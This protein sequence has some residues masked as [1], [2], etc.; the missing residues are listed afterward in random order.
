M[1]RPVKNLTVSILKTP[2]KKVSGAGL[3]QFLELLARQSSGSSPR[4]P[5]AAA[6]FNLGDEQVVGRD[7]I[8]ERG[9]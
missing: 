6:V 8:F 3:S 9:N 4:Q 7:F 5:L 1:D 2:S